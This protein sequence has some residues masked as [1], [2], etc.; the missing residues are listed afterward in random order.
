YSTP[1]FGQAPYI[2]NAMLNYSADSIRFA[3]S[4]SYNVQG[5]RLAVS[6]SEID[7]SGIRAYEMPR[8]L[9]DITVNKSFGAHWGVRLRARNLLNAPQRRAYLFD[10]GFNVDFDKYTYGSEYLLTLTYSIR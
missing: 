4:L 7:P 2:I 8:H 9:I 10:Q 5:A 1:M 6:N 3:I